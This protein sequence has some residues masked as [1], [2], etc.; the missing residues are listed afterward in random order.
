M[1]KIILIIGIICLT[2]FIF[3]CE[4]EEEKEWRE[5]TERLKSAVQ[6]HEIIKQQQDVFLAPDYCYIDC[7]DECELKYEFSDCLDVCMR[8]YE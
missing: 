7:M 4:T 2:V 8:C 1:K 5:V 6:E 3:G